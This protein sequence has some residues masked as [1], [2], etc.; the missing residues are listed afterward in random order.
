MNPRPAREIPDPGLVSRFVWCIRYEQCLNF[1]VG[2]GWAGFSCMFCDDF[3]AA[4]WG[5]EDLAEDSARC[6]FLWGIVGSGDE[7]NARLNQLRASTAATFLL[8][9]E[10]EQ[11]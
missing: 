1:A 10:R 8:A 3:Q 9:F 2:M 6:M 7:D 4:T 5:Q 11:L